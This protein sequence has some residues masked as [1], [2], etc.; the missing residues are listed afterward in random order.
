MNSKLRKII[1]DVAITALVGILPNGKADAT[2]I[3]ASVDKKLSLLP[4]NGHDITSNKSIPI[5]R[6]VYNYATD[7]GMFHRS[8]RSHSSHSSHRSHYSSTSGTSNVKSTIKD[9]VNNYNRVVHPVNPNANIIK[10]VTTPTLGSRTL[11]YGMQGED[12]LELKK[13]LV[14]AKC[15]KMGDYEILDGNFDQKTHDAVNLFKK[16]HQLS[17][18]GLVDAVVTYHLKN[19]Q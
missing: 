13:A 8:H 6:Y 17:Q 3:S 14:K 4:G 1:R 16:N 12:V 2:I 15:Y 9:S 19:G 10:S 7:D 11:K 18:D 5:L